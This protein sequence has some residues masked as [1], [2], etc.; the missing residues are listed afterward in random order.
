MLDMIS[1]AVAAVMAAMY[2]A[3][4]GALAFAGLRYGWRRLR[5]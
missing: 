2:I 3:T 1:H 5:R 4:A